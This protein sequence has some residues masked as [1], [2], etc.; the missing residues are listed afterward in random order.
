MHKQIN[1]TVITHGQ[2]HVCT[3]TNTNVPT[4]IYTIIYFRYYKQV[5]ITYITYVLLL[6]FIFYFRLEHKPAART[7]KL[8]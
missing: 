6:L 4:C 8:I 1:E 3:L 2:C 5:H 7:E